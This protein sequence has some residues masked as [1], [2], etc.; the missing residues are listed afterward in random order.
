MLRSAVGERESVAEGGEQ[1]IANR[2]RSAMPAAEPQTEA[3]RTCGTMRMQARDERTE[4]RSGT[5]GA[6][7]QRGRRVARGAQ[8][9]RALV[10]ANL[11]TN[12]MVDQSPRR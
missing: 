2:S 9:D 11:T 6:E 8:Q 1:R 12:A 7:G 4:L 5:G 3:G 10:T